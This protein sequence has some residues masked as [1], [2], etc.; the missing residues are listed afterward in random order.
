VAGAALSRPRLPRR[1]DHGEEASLVE[2][3]DELRQRLFF[4][5]GAVAVGAV[6]GF[7]IHNRLIHYLKI[8]LPKNHRELTTLTVGEPFMTSLWVSI[9]FG[10]LLATPIILWQIWSFFI[11]A[12]ERTHAQLMRWFVVAA[13]V[14]LITGI[15]FGYFVALPAA[16]HF[17][18]NYDNQTYHVVIQAKP[19]LTFATQVLFAMGIVFELPLF[20]IGLTRLGIVTTTK[21]RKNRRIGYF[22]VACVGV[23]L[24]GVDPVTTTIETL[25]LCILFEASIWASILLD[26]RS[27]QRDASG[28]A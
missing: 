12:V 27:E 19:F 24:P 18:T 15:V 1:L 2:H 25:P 21:L 20:V 16:E 26:R 7:V 23:A 14:L 22:I 11:P 10:L 17:L 3:L 6:I 4:C 9:Y 5:I 8:T 28:A 13:T